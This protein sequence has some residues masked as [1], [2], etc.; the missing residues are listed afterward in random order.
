VFAL[1]RES[2]LAPE[3]KRQVLRKL[4]DGTLRVRT[5]GSVSPTGF[6]FKVHELEGTLSDPAIR[7]ARQRR[8]DLGYLRQPVASDGELV[9]VCPAEPGPTFKSKGGRQQQATGRVCLCNALF[10]AAGLPQ[11]RQDGSAET[12]IFTG[13]ADLGTV[14]HLSP[15]GDD[16]RATA[17]ISFI[18]TG[19]PN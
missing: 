4:A 17:A 6:P 2:G 10:A 8:C 5:D 16:Y 3:L 1:S 9:Y 18:R 12:P 11:Q 14:R 19:R 13:G 15:D 7:D